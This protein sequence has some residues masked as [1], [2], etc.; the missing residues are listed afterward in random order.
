[1]ADRELGS[2]PAS[3]HRSRRMRRG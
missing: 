2:G 3:R 1:M